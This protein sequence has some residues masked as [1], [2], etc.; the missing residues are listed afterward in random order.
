MELAAGAVLLSFPGSYIHTATHGRNYRVKPLP[1][2]R[3]LH[4]TSLHFTDILY[5]NSIARTEKTNN[6]ILKETTETGILS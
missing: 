6:I 2:Q 3:V 1:V 4:H 5:K